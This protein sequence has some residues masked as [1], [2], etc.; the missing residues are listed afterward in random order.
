AAITAA[1][2][3]R[4]EVAR[5]LFDTYLKQ[6]F[7]DGF[8]HADPHPGNLFVSPLTPPPDSNEA[9][10]PA[11]QLT[12]IDF[13]MVGR[14]PSN[15]RAGLREAAIGI[16]SKDSA[17]LVKAYRM[18]GVLLPSVN[19]ELLERAEAKIFERFWGKTM[20]EL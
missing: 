20:T 3:D 4:A 1:G 18:M 7:E 9:G 14:V 19:L 2:I 10:G 6:I 16:G 8:F 17:R 5:R 12:F 13:G 15:L 11:W